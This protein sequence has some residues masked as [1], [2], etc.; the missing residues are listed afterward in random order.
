MHNLLMPDF[1]I[2]DAD[3]TRRLVAPRLFFFY[4]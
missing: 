1:R 2:F 4:R 3:L